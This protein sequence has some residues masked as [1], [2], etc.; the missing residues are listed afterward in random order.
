MNNILQLPTPAGANPQPGAT[1][2]P[3]CEIFDR[4]ADAVIGCFAHHYDTVE[5]HGVRNHATGIDNGTCYEVDNIAPT[6]FSVY[7]RLKD[8][9]LDCVGDFSNSE[10]AVH[11]GTEV[12]GMY[13]WPV[14]DYVLARHR[15]KSLAKL[16]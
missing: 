4:Y 14:H 16:Q 2:E 5:V 6:S 3:P 12:G 8:G 10:D 7:A 11:Y 13:G 15:T 1:A 9:G